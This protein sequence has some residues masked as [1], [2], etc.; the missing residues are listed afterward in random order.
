MKSFWQIIWSHVES[1]PERIQT[2]NLPFRRG[3]LYPVELQGLVWLDIHCV[4]HYGYLVV[5]WK[6]ITCHGAP[7]RIWTR[8]TWGRNPLL[9]PLS[10][11]GM[12]SA[13]ESNLSWQ[14]PFNHSIILMSRTTLPRVFKVLVKPFPLGKTQDV[15]VGKSSLQMTLIISILDNQCGKC[16][17]HPIKK[18]TIILWCLSLVRLW[19]YHQ[20]MRKQGGGKQHYFIQ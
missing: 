11:G 6:I 7:G 14:L 15:F 17:H 2:S 19:S 18:H 1:A 16:K 5:M 8:D 3:V 4:N 13:N 10:Y 12:C 20:M 9:Y